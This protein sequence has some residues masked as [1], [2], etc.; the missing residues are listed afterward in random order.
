MNIELDI[1][2]NCLRWLKSRVNAHV[3]KMYVFEKF[4]TVFIKTLLLTP[5]ILQKS[6]FDSKLDLNSQVTGMKIN[7]TLLIKIKLFWVINHNKDKQ[8]AI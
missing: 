4:K 2:I 8:I 7:L 1:D 5:K 6:S 3:M